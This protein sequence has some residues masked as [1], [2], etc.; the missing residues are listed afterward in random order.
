MEQ[1]ATDLLV[2]GSSLAGVSLAIQAKEAGLDRVLVIEPGDQVGAAEVIAQ[3]AITVEFLAPVRGLSSITNPSASLGQ[4]ATAGRVLVTCNRLEM[5]ADL[6]AVALRPIRISRP[7]PVAASL[8]DRVHLVPPAIDWRDSDVLV[9]GVDEE[10]AEYS[11]WLAGQGAGVVL[12]FGGADLEA[13]SRLA[14]RQLLRLEAERRA[15]ILWNSQPEAIEEVAGFPMVY[16][17]DRRTPDLQ[18]DHVVFRHPCPTEETA[19]TGWDIHLSTEAPSRVYLVDPGAEAAT[20]PGGVKTVSPGHVWDSIRSEHYPHIPAPSGRPR[21]WRHGDRHQIEELRATNYNATITEFERSHSDLW[22]LRVQPDHGDTHHLAG[23]YASLG[24]GYWEP[25][26]DA[27]R[28]PGLERSWGKLIRRSYSISSPLFDSTGYL[29]DPY[30]SPD[31]EFYVV[32]VPPAADRVPALT[33]RLA[34]K[35]PGDRIDL[36]P[37]VAGRYTLSGIADPRRNLVFL[38]TGTGEAPHN[39]MIVESLR[40]GHWGPIV[41]VISVRHR[42]DLGYLDQHRELEERFGQYRYLPLVTRDPDQPKL[43]VQDVIVKGMLEEQLAAP[44]APAVTDVF[45]CGNPAM[46]G[47]PANDPEGVTEY[48]VPVGV[49]QLLTERGFV[50]EGR[51]VPGNIHYEEYW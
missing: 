26:I 35:G 40:R 51:G 39:A 32:L 17:G 37:K 10:A 43:Y 33:P 34:M 48:P 7:F 22:V 47:L 46:I 14:R 24:L 16:F 9:V 12:A 19:I 28:D 20:V 8:A 31:L 38:A 25:R 45:L 4:E 5:T 21:V 11:W 27:A 29:F 6:V 3:H 36:G 42:S 44:L 50:I 15:T 2:I 41:S 30:R 23:Q 49:C 1:T 18:F 13:L